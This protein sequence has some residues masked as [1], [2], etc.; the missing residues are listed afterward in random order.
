MVVDPPAGEIVANGVYGAL[1]ESSFLRL[2]LKYKK[3][4]KKAGA[5]RDR[6]QTATDIAKATGI[7]HIKQWELEKNATAGSFFAGSFYYHR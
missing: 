2:S 3:T 6:H 1:W 5:P 4:R 7:W